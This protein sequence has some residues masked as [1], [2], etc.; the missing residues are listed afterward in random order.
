MQKVR[1]LYN[2][3]GLLGQFFE[4]KEERNFI[5]IKIRTIEAAQ[6]FKEALEKICENTTMC[7]IPQTAVDPLLLTE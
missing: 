1:E 3:M 2:R 6:V 7:Q 5:K 4:D